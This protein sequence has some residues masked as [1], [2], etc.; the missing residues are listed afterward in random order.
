MK[1]L[2]IKLG[3]YQQPCF[4]YVKKPAGSKTSKICKERTEMEIEEKTFNG[5]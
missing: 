2:A 4:Y 5:I 3:E 1:L